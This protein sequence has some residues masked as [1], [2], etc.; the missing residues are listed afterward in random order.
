VGNPSK[1]GSP[2]AVFDSVLQGTRR[3]LDL[4]EASG[5]GRFLQL[6]SGAVYG[7]QPVAMHRLAETYAGGPDPLQPNAAYGNAKR[8]AEAL[9]CAYAEQSA[10]LQVSIARIFALLGPGL[11]LNGP[12]AAGNFVRDA[13]AG[14]PIRMASDGRPVR[15]YLYTADLCVWLLRMAVMGGSGQ[16]Y[17]VGSEHD[18]S[19]AELAQQLA[20]QAGTTVAAST[21]VVVCGDKLLPPRYVPDTN[22]A[23]RELGL[24]Q[25]TP[26]DAALDKTLRWARTTRQT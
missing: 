10:A 24:A 11:P 3:M 4:S 14:N 16:A 9:V 26:L 25:Y 23:R 18:V 2:L 8:A 6:S 21:D 19:I 17:N 7:T 5:A 15:S 12:Y 1:I 20:A 13:I 22:K